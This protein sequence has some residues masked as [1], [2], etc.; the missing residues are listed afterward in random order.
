MTYLGGIQQV[1][2]GNSINCDLMIFFFLLFKLIHVWY[3][4]TVL[5]VSNNFD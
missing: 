4:Y 1:S 5:I 2:P 3:V